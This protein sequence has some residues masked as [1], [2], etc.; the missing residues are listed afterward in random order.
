MNLSLGLDIGGT[1]VAAGLVTPE[2]E[3]V[4]KTRKPMNAHGTAEAAMDSVRAAIDDVLVHAPSSPGAIGVTAPGP[5]SPRDGLVLN[6]PN[7]PCWRNFPL[8]TEVARI[9]GLPV[10][11][12]N[13][14][15]AAGLAE[16]IW[17][18]GAGY[19]NVFYASIGTG[20]G[21]G[22]IFDRQIYLGRTGA[23]A[24]G[25]HVSIDYKGPVC[26]CG[27]RGCIEVLASG[28][29]IGARARKI[30]AADAK[31]GAYLLELASGH[32]DKINGELVGRAWE[33]GD[34]LANEV[35]QETAKLL[36]VWLGDIIDLLEPDII[37]IGG[38]VSSLIAQWFPAISKTIAA[39]SI[40]AR[41]LEI[42]LVKAKYGADAGIAGAAA[43][44]YETSAML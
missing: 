37:V 19:R 6:P 16:A 23:A 20:I 17:G 18:A 1:K 5:L 24:E 21:T 14:G 28:N 32:L 12:N 11:V 10:F 13:D 35:L 40:N 30:V 2:G 41:C 26:G 7:L 42:P 27:K 4:Y 31:R 9:Y 15:N 36:G 22:I 34:R 43:L 33:A 8:G 38:G 3:I 29:A 39:C 44:C 25:G